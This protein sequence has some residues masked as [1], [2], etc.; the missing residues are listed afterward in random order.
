MFSFLCSK[1]ALCSW[2]FWYIKWA[3]LQQNFQA[4]YNLVGL[5]APELIALKVHPGLELKT[6][7]P[8][9]SLQPAKQRRAARAKHFGFDAT[10][11]FSKKIERW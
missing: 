7:C 5:R 6:E 8:L 3:L 10:T 11:F 1:I 2:D 9:E 4:L